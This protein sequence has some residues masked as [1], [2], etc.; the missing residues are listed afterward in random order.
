MANET[1]QLIQIAAREHPYR[2]LCFA[3]VKRAI[4]DAKGRGP[5]LYGED[6]EEIQREARSLTAGKIGFWIEESYVPPML[7]NHKMEEI[8]E[9]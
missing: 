6:K 8:N 2:T 1:G 5:Y 3:V 9:R 4:W 7:F